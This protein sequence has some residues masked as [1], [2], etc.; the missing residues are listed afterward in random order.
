MTIPLPVIPRTFRCSYIWGHGGFTPTPVNV[1]HVRAADDATDATGVF[2]TLAASQQT[3]MYMTQLTAMGVNQINIIKLDGVD[4][5]HSFA[6]DGSAHWNG[7]GTGDGIPQA[8]A[9]VKIQTAVRGRA[10]RGRIYLPWVAEAFV[11]NGAIT[12]L[13]ETNITSAFQAW[14]NAM[15]VATTPLTLGVASYDRAHSGAGAHFTPYVGILC[16][17]YTATQRRRQ[18]A[19]KVTRHRHRLGA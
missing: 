2:A 15:S 10:N 13:L 16:E 6:T 7:Q 17:H 11:S 19:R 5:T 8:C 9:L 4:P 18:P 1:I 12:S 3:N 14:A